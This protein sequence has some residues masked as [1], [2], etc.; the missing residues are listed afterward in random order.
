MK[1]TKN[2]INIEDIYSWLLPKLLTEKEIVF[3]GK[4][5]FIDPSFWAVLYCEK[6]RRA[7]KKEILDIVVDKKFQTSPGYNYF[8][9]IT[10]K[11]TSYTT[12]PLKAIKTVNRDDADV[13][14]KEV[15]ELMGVEDSNFISYLNYIVGE[16]I[17]NA[18]DHSDSISETVCT[19]QLFPF[20]NYS[21][22][23]VADAGVG[24]YKTIK[25]AYKDIEKDD[26]AIEKA[27]Q[28]G[29][30]GY[31]TNRGKYSI[32][33]N[34]GMGLYFIS[35]MLKKFDG[36]LKI[37]SGKG[38]LTQIGDKIYK[39]YSENTIWN[40]SIVIV[41]LYHKNFSILSLEEFLKEMRREDKEEEIF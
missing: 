1:I 3:E 12:V 16:L 32:Y 41:R 37:I 13:F 15:V 17:T 18:V 40:G 24:F 27:I 26:D 39:E 11:T 5:D 22:I 23:V 14:A 2:K 33:K 28:K 30:R 29:V 6:F 36:F 8:L 20:G 35:T 9:R 19:G 38:I 21:E 34:A 25:K 31:T 7:A 10:D 4:K